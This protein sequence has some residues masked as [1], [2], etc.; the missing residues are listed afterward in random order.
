MSETNNQWADEDAKMANEKF[1]KV[2]FMGVTYEVPESHVAIAVDSS[3]TVISYNTSALVIDEET[4]DQ[5]SFFECAEDDDWYI[6]AE[7][8][9]DDVIDTWAT[10][11]QAI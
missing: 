9:P 8:D 2:K 5:W 10:S 1:K 11:L 4:H 6:V 3:G 7:L